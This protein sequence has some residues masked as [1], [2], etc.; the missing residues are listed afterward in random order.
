MILPGGIHYINRPLST[1]FTATGTVGRL[2]PG[3]AV[4]FSAGSNRIPSG[5]N[6]VTVCADS[7]HVVSER[8][9]V[10]NCASEITDVVPNFV[11]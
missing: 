3:A 1:A 8:S 11:S 7:A 6:R 2:A 10:N 5:L 9:E 4:Q